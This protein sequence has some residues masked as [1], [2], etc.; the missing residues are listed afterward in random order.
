MSEFGNGV[1]LPLTLSLTI[2]IVGEG[3]WGEG[4]PILGRYLGQ[5]ICHEDCSLKVEYGNCNM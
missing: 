1:A 5:K 4:V 2:S 3:G